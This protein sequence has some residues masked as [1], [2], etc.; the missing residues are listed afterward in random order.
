MRYRKKPVEVEAWQVGS[1]EECPDWILSAK[2]MCDGSGMWF[3]LCDSENGTS[4]YTDEGNYIINDG[5]FYSRWPS[6]V[7]DGNYSEYSDYEVVE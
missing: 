3:V 2:P 1:D 4:F 7:F 5:G 6:D